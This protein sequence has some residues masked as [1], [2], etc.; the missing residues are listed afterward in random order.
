MAFH[1][2]AQRWP[3]AWQT[4]LHLGEAPTAP[5]TVELRNVSSTGCV[6]AAASSPPV[7]TRIRF[8]A[9]GDDVTGHV[10][11]LMLGGGAIAF[12]ARLSQR[13]L[14][15]L[16]QYRRLNGSVA[17]DARPPEQRATGQSKADLRQAVRNIL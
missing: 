17:A 11:R 15:S 10:V 13:Q 6:F 7:G 4:V 9:S 1:E 16:R 5:M 2:R 8:A 14:G 12:E 3:C